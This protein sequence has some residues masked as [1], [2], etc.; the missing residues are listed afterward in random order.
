[1]KTNI[2]FDV[3]KFSECEFEDHGQVEEHSNPDSPT[4]KTGEQGLEKH[5]FILE[6]SRTKQNRVKNNR[7]FVM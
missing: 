1:M 2:V 4:K 6:L 7:Q 3:E 5:E